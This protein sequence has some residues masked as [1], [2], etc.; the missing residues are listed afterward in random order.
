MPLILV[1]IAGMKA[2]TSIG[3]MLIDGGAERFRGTITIALFFISYIYRS[4]IPIR[5]IRMTRRKISTESAIALGPQQRHAIRSVC[6]GCLATDSVT[7]RCI[8]RRAA[9]VSGYQIPRAGVAVT[10]DAGPETENKF[11]VRIAERF[12]T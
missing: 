3:A 12:C 1:V 7:C 4:V 9:S 6:T 11:A 10:K 8:R 5:K 2:N